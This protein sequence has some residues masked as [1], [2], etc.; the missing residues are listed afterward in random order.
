MKAHHWTASLILIAAL[1]AGIAMRAQQPATQD[2]G[3]AK[4]GGTPKAI[5][6]PSPALPDGPIPLSTGI[7]RDLRIVVTKGLVQP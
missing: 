6:W 4:A 1:A 2:K 7:E 3:K 5:P